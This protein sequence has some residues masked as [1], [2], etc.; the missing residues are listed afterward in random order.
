MSGGN[1]LTFMTLSSSSSTF[2]GLIHSEVK[3]DKGKAHKTKL[4]WRIVVEN[5]HF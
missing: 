4:K 2:T 5:V 1:H 3:Q